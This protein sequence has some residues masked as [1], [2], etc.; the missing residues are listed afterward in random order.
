MKK[1]IVL[2]AIFIA[3]CSNKV[4]LKEVNK[5]AGEWVSTGTQF[6]MGSDEQVEIV[7]SLIANYAAMDADAVFTGTRDS[8][9]FFPFNLEEPLIMTADDIK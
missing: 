6:L 9:R 7:K 5:K 8:L 4:E 3:S 2:M 1:L